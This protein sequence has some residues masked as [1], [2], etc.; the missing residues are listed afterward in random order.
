[1][2]TIV[3]NIAESG[4]V[5]IPANV[6]KS[7]DLSIGD[8]LIMQVDDRK[9][10]LKPRADAIKRAQ[11]LVAKYAVNRPKG[12]VVEEFIKERREEAKRELEV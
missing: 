8:E 11:E 7:L 10:T 1:M 9:I 4:R 2:E 12:S 5:L 6:R 3:T